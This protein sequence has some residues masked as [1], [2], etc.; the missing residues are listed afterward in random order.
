[1]PAE[2][3]LKLENLQCTG[4]FKVRGAGN[5]IL[6]AA[7]SG[8]SE[9]WTASAGNMGLAVA[10]YAKRLG[11]RCTVIVP[12]DAPVEKINAIKLL[13]A[14]AVPL[15]REEYWGIQKSHQREGMSGFFVHPFADPDVMAGNGTIALEILE[16]LPD[17]DTV[18]V[19]Y[20]GGG[21]SCG[22]ASVFRALRPNAKVCAAETENG[23]PLAP[24]LARGRMIEVPYW[25]S[26]VSGIGSPVVFGEMWPLA[27]RLLTASIVVRLEQIVE[28]MALLLRYDHV[29][30]EGAGA[31]SL[32]A[33]QSG[34]VAGG[35]VVCVISGGNIDVDTAMALFREHDNR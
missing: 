15:P 33:A 16:E 23:A 1:L 21:L 34:E 19:P 20:G 6:K 7:S 5:A 13:S 9:V 31:V 17:V 8:V 4:S 28:S 26:F 14:E 11:M 25:K 35:R 18:I 27:R 10:W 2:V 24:S 3:F 30:A 29:L 22:I 12:E 32:A